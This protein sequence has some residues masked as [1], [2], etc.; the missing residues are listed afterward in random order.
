MNKPL[1]LAFATATLF[2]L[3]LTAQ[4]S[5]VLT[6]QHF[7][8]MGEDGNILPTDSIGGKNFTGGFGARST[9]STVHAPGSTGSLQFG[10]GP[11]A[12]STGGS[13]METVANGIAVPLDNWVLELWVNP[14][15]QGNDV[16]FASAGSGQ[17]GW[18]QIGMESGGRAFF[19]RSNQAYGPMTSSAIA[20]GTWTHLAYVRSGGVNYGYV[21]GVQIGTPDSGTPTNNGQLHIGIRPGNG[22]HLTGYLDEMRFSTFAPGTFNSSDLLV[23]AVPEPASMA[24]LGFGALAFLKRRRKS[25]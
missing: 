4:A 10:A 2:S 5:A 16:T 1:G 23:N 12:P 25:S 14:L 7:W 3:G 20:I 17:A 9:S 21:N 6:V 13:Y 22:Q 18:S 24:V 19:G 15:V 8:H 11:S